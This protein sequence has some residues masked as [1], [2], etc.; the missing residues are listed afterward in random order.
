MIGNIAEMRCNTS[1]YFSGII[2]KALKG[3]Q[4]I[5]GIYLSDKSNVGE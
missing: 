2:L 3:N 1:C 4:I 5:P